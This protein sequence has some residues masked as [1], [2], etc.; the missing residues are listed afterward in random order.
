MLTNTGYRVPEKPECLMTH[1]IIT[2]TEKRLWIFFQSHYRSL[3]F[4]FSEDGGQTWTSPQELLPDI[5]G[6]FSAAAGAGGMVFVVARKTNHPDI[7]LLVW[8][9]SQWSEGVLPSPGK[10]VITASPLVAGGSGQ[11]VHV[12]YAARGYSSG[13]W[14]VKHSLLETGRGEIFDRPVPLIS[15]PQ[16]EWPPRLEFLRESLYWAGDIALDSESSLHLACSVFSGSHYQIYH[17]FCRGAS[18]Q[19]G[20]FS[21]LTAAPFHSTHPRLL[22]GQ[23]NGEIHAFLQREKEG[24][25]TL[26]GLSRSPEGKWGSEKTIAVNLKGDFPAEPVKTPSGTA[27]YWSYGGG[28]SRSL[29]GISCPTEKIVKEKVTSFSACS[30]LEKVFLACS[31]LSGDKTAIFVAKDRID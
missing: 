22:A 31:G 10:Q 24:G 23:V 3:A 12:V 16:P 18:G 2:D 4:G 6:P 5:S 19:W 15:A 28:I 9:G 21:P 29:F 25:H 30:S 14:A 20:A 11:E 27:L 8:N 7:Y 26:I 17:S 1:R 13:E